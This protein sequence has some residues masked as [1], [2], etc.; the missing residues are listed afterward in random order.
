[1]RRDRW[2]AP[3]TAAT[4]NPLTTNDIRESVLGAAWTNSATS[5][6][7]AIPA[8]QSARFAV[9]IAR[10][11]GTADFTQARCQVTANVMNANGLSSPFDAQ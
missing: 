7:Y 11:S 2:S 3:T 4:W 8:T 1:M 9:G 5:G 6:I 10:H